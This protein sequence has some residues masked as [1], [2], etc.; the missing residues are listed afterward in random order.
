MILRQLMVFL[1]VA[2]SIQ[3]P[4]M[5]RAEAAPTLQAQEIDDIFELLP[6]ARK[7]EKVYEY[8][9]R[10]APH[11][12]LPA[13]MELGEILRGHELDKM[14]KVTVKGREATFDS[15]K[16]KAVVTVEEKGKDVVVRLNGQVLNPKEIKS[17]TAL[18]AKIDTILRKGMKSNTKSALLWSIAVSNANADIDWMSFLGGGV[19]GA[20][21]GWFGKGWWD[22]KQ[23]A[24][25][26]QNYQCA[27]YGQCCAVN[28]AQVVGCCNQMQATSGGIV[29]YHIGDSTTNCSGPYPPQAATTAAPLGT[30]TP[31]YKSNTNGNGI[32]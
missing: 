10:L 21:I 11:L 23:Q 18:A 1:A 31:I 15:G 16:V 19:L 28:G 5:S 32:Q 4:A 26:A 25:A 8:Y 7:D 22:S 17:V 29:V 24:N 30:G 27:S 9:D 20:V 2:G 12:P 13:R 3:A 6:P 14:P